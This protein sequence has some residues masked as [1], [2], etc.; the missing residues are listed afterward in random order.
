MAE[1]FVNDLAFTKPEPRHKL[2]ARDG[3]VTLQQRGKD[4]FLVRYGKQVYAGL[5]YAEAAAQYGACVMHQ[6]ACDGLLDNRAKG[7]RC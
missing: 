4:N 1:Y 7:E 6:A 2:C 5:R 3:L